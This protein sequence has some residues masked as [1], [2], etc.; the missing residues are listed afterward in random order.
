MANVFTLFAMRLNTEAV[1]ISAKHWDRKSR[2]EPINDMTSCYDPQVVGK[3]LNLESN[4]VHLTV[5][6]AKSIT[7][8]IVDTI[9]VLIVLTI[10]GLNVPK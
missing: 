5:L 7:M 8:G 3:V 4:P 2:E 1:A 6:A 9:W 10:P